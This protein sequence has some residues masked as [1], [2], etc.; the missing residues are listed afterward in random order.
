M[1]TVMPAVDGVLMWGLQQLQ[2][3]LVQP[4]IVAV[5]ALV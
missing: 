4:Q 3:V 1:L 5:D 2:K